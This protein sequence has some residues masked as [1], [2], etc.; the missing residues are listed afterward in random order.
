MRAGALR[1]AEVCDGW[2]GALVSLGWALGENWHLI[3]KYV[4]W[5]QY[6]VIAVVAFLIV[7]FVWQR[8]RTR[9]VA[10]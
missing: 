3:E 6:L 10:G 5:L 1:T 2:I 9:R 7:R 8:L 4:G